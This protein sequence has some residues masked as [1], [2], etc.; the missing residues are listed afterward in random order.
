MATPCDITAHV[1]QSRWPRSCRWFSRGPA[2]SYPNLFDAH[3]PFQIDGN[4]GGTAAT[5]EML[6]Q[7]HAGELRL[8]V[9][10]TRATRVEPHAKATAPVPL[11]HRTEIPVEPIEG[12]LDGLPQAGPDVAVASIPEDM[13]LVRFRRAQQPEH[14]K[15]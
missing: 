12:V 13:L 10:D 11:L 4:F 3:P 5:A 8:D 9:V 6:L 7:S 15:L 1:E 14:R 2:R